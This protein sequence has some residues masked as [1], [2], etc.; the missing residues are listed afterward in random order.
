MSEDSQGELSDYYTNIA[1]A[2]ENNW[3][4][5][6]DNI[7]I[8]TSSTVIAQLQDLTSLEQATNDLMNNFNRSAAEYGDYVNKIE[9]DTQT[10]YGNVGEL[11][12]G[13]ID[14]QKALT[15]AT[16]DF[17]NLVRQD[18]D[19]INKNNAALISYRE[20]IEKLQDSTSK[21]NQ[22]MREAQELASAKE[23]EARYWESKY[24]EL[25]TAVD[26]GSY[27]NQGS[28][29]GG[30]GSVSSEEAAFG[31]AQNIWTYG[32]WENDP[33]RRE[34]I[35]SRYG[36]DVANRAQEIVNDYY[37]SGRAG[38]LY[39]TDSWSWGYDTGGYTG[40]WSDKTDEPKNGKLAYLHQ[41]ELVLNESDTQ[42]ILDAVS[43][44][45]EF[46]KQ[47]KSNS[48]SSLFDSWGS[49]YAKKDNEQTVKQDVHIT[50]EF[51]NVNSASEIE[52][53]LESLNQRAYQYVQKYR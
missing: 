17:W 14:K 1:D 2:M 47:L 12:D 51:P 32:S 25:K 42:N 26:N 36:E 21:A 46:T 22:A 45:R 30:G 8:S 44:V 19:Q 3:S 39:N 16:E 10:S 28:G 6:M 37:Y 35:I 13:V 29:G 18:T 33:V 52:T 4:E 53:A 24:T 50:A 43:L 38:E 5:A 23:Q 41:K 31:I 27:F 9:Q 49:N 11:I 7:G 15:D 48:L 40:T 20:E 34:R